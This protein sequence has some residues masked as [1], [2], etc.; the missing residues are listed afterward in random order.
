MDNIKQMIQ[1]LLRGMEER[2]NG[3]MAKFEEKMDDYHKK[4]M[5]MLDVHHKSIMAN[6]ENTVP[7]QK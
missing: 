4:R 6:T 2:M 5:A 7:I 1:D 3:S